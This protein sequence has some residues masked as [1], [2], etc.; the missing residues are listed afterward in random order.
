MKR[1][2]QERFAQPAVGVTVDS[3]RRRPTGQ[4]HFD[5]LSREEQDAMLG[6]EVAEKVRAGE[7]TLAD[8]LHRTAPG[9]TPGFIVQKPLQDL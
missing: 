4:E 1:P 2:E 7:V 8:L 9:D 6:P 3:S 5:A